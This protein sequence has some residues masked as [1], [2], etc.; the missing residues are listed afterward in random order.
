VDG[1]AAENAASDQLGHVGVVV[2]A[3]ARH[4]LDLAALNGPV[5]AP[6]LGSQG[7]TAHDLRAVFD[8]PPP[9]LLPS[10]S[11]DILRHGPDPDALRRAAHAVLAELATGA[12]TLSQ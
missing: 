12:A 4:G 9:L 7:A 8:R 11:R 6:G 1:A 5:L 10:T 3:T 2:G